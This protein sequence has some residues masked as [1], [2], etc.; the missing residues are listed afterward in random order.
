M[1]G[2]E[3]PEHAGLFTEYRPLLF[4]IAYEMLGSAVDAD[5]VLQDSYLRWATVDLDVIDNP[6]GYLA[7]IVT[8]QSLNALRASSRRREEYIGTWL[9]EPILVDEKEPLDD[10]V[11]AESLSTAMLVVLETLSPNERAVFVLHEVFGFSHDEIASIV[12]RSPVAVRQTLHR[13]RLH[14]EARRPQFAPV[15]PKLAAAVVH[16]FFAAAARGDIDELLDVLRP[17][18]VWT[19]DGGGKASAARRPVYGAEA[20]GRLVIGLLRY[21]ERHHGSTAPTLLNGLPAVV[22]SLDGEMA[23]VLVFEI[24]DSRIGNIFAVR[25]PDKLGSVGRPRRVER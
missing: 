22:L 15:D 5:D 9:P 6:R 25:N 13:A 14:V 8:R 24:V 17:D 20:V 2:S 7:R 11:L 21:G 4:T 19:A 16:R 12:D 10:V 18:A 23:G 1:S 3:Q